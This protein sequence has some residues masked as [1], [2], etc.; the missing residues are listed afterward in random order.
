MSETSEKIRELVTVLCEKE[1]SQTR[2]AKRIGATP[3][4]V[5]NWVSGRNGPDKGALIAISQAYG[6]PLEKLICEPTIEYSYIK[7]SE[8]TDP[9]IDEV[10]ACMKRMNEK[11]RRAVLNVARAMVE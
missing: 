8:N 10:G 11:Q 1:G 4:K 7:F 5:N 6:I 2:F 9:D 3:Q